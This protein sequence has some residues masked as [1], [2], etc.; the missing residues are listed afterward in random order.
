MHAH[1]LLPLNTNTLAT[2]CK[3]L[4]HWKRPW[5]WERLKAGEEDDRGWDTWMASPTHH[6]LSWA[7]SRRWWRTGNP[8]ML[9]SM[10][11]QRV[12]HDCVSEQQQQYSWSKE[13]NTRDQEGRRSLSEVREVEGNGND[14]LATWDACGWTS[15]HRFIMIKL[16]ITRRHWRPQM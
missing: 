8:D 15:Q 11:L 4:T 3:E 1:D 16:E 7:S 9:Q 13:S 6:Q 10:G 12:R 5:C 2:W 14:V